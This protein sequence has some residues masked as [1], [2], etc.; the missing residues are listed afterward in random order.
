M[1]WREA[2]HPRNPASGEFVD[3][4]GWAGVVAFEAGLRGA[5]KGNQAYDSVGRRV[6]WS[7][8]LEGEGSTQRMR[9]AIADYYRH[10]DETTNAHLR[11]VAG[12]PLSRTETWDPPRIESV[13]SRIEALDQAMT[14]L[15]RS[16][17]VYRGVGDLEQWLARG[18]ELGYLSTST[19][20]STAGGFAEAAGGSKVRILVPAG[21]GAVGIGPDEMEV[22][23]QRGLRYRLVRRTDTGADVEVLGPGPASMMVPWARDGRK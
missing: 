13:E 15:S 11:G 12:P 20:P 2:D 18:R 4:A 14:P 3:K 21:V 5:L 9:D 19:D 8:E 17:V 6:E 16:I 7:G 10:Y 23:L 22:L 1:G